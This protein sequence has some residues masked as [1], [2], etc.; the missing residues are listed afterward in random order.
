MYIRYTLGK[1]TFVNW[2]FDIILTDLRN[3]MITIKQK[4]NKKQAVQKF[5]FH[6]IKQLFCHKFLASWFAEVSIQEC[7][8]LQMCLG[9]KQ[10][11]LIIKIRRNW[12][13]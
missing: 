9:G 6:T 8:K 2:N 12:N 5:H 3:S 11:L 7:Q 4:Q 1:K 10:W 13:Q